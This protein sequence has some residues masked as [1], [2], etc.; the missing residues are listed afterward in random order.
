MEYAVGQA[1]QGRAGSPQPTEQP[2]L[3]ASL[4]RANKNRHV[5]AEAAQRF[6]QILLRLTTPTPREA[7]GGNTAKQ[8]SESF[9]SRF[10]DHAAELE[11]LGGLLH[12]I[13]DR[14]DRAI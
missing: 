13:A 1:A 7:I 10:S 9:Q 2:T 4:D 5:I 14:F 3:Q 8:V 6:E 11:D 12:N